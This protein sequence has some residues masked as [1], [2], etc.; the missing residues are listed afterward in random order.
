M[1]CPRIELV[2][3]IEV[4]RNGNPSCRFQQRGETRLHTGDDGIGVAAEDR[5]GRNTTLEDLQD[6]GFESCERGDNLA[7]GSSR[8]IR[9][10][11]L[12]DDFEQ[13]TRAQVASR[14]QKSSGA[15]NRVV[16]CRADT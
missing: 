6:N 8:D 11:I 9:A 7:V 10:S 12:L 15:C 4:D 1:R 2:Q 5:I 14:V 13:W 3:L 16:F